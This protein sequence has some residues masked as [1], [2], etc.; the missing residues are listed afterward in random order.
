[1]NLF[2][3]GDATTAAS[4]RQMT[5]VAP[6]ALF[7]M[8]SEFVTERAVNLAKALLSN[9]SLEDAAR[10]R[11]AY[12]KVLSREATPQEVGRGLTYV[13]EF[14]KR[15]NGALSAADAW[16]SLCRIL[17]ASNEFIYLD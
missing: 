2:D 15:S 10:I 4:K 11:A 9:A 12:I 14:Q 13:S 1:L 6:Q 3:F 16:T 5:T 7:M 17:L 8:N